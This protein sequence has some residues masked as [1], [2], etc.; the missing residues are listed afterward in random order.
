MKKTIVIAV[1]AALVGSLYAQSVSDLA[2]Q[3]KARRAALGTNRA[4]VV[5][6]ADLAAVR[7][8]PAVVVG[9]PDE[10]QDPNQPTVLPSGEPAGAD[11]VVMN[12]TVIKNGPE[13]F[14]KAESG[15]GAD[16][17]SRL[18]A[19]EELVDLLTTKLNSLMQQSN[20]LD[21]MT[22]K[23][24]ILQQIETTTQKLQRVQDEVARLKG[25]VEAGKQGAPD[26]R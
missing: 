3:E 6:N 21:T 17:A 8:T 4:K 10:A 5:T 11:G 14:S 12:P 26:K 16:T 13:L 22:P 15:P 9:T 20:S 18:K 24:A 1:F 19:A 2:K 25:Q 7:K 23:D